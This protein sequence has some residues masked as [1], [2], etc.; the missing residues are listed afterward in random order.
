MD[1]LYTKTYNGQEMIFNK[2][3][4]V[5]IIELRKKF[6]YAGRIFN[7][8]LGYSNEGFGINSN[9]IQFVL[10]TKSKLLIH[11][12]TSETNT[13]YWIKWDLI[14]EFIKSHNHIKNIEN[15]KIINVPVSLFQNKPAFSGAS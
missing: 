7:W 8:G 14:Q 15:V 5:V 6:N 13:E 10:G 12:Q 4:K 9:I 2:N 3:S 11:Y 1:P